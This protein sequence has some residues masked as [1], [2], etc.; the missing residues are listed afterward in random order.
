MKLEYLIPG[1]MS[2]GV[3]GPEEILRRQSI[4]QGWACPDVE[5]IARDIDDGPQSVESAYEEYLS[6]PGAMKGIVSAEADG[7]SGVIIGCFGDPGLDSARELVSIPV[8]GPGECSMH[9][10]AMLG[11]S[12]SV[13][14]VMQN[15]VPLIK[16]LALL[17]GLQS[18][19]ASVRT[20][21]TAV[22]DLA[23]SRERTFKRLVEVGAK[24]L[25][26]DGADT[27]ILGCLS[28]AFLEMSE[29]LGE[30]LAVPV[31][32]PARTALKYLEALV[33]AKL[34]HSKRA[35]L[36]PPKLRMLLPA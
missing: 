5:V 15:V 24:A 26:Q 6:I 35:F 10:A 2:K 8:V 20:I 9:F 13:I 18:K 1:A 16:K 33:S 29:Q 31:I 11:H 28:F 19:L 36:T 22:L 4:L 27:L 30:E 3:L 21:E 25:E 7:T 32:N 17:A 12:F 14:T 34:T 23:G